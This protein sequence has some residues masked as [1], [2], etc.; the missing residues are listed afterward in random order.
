MYSFNSRVRYSEIDQRGRLSVPAVINYLQDCSTLQ[1]EDLGKG[2]SYMKGQH[3]AWWLSSWQIVIDRRPVLGEPITVSTWPYDF[4]G[5]YGYRNFTIQDKTGAYLVRANSVWFLFDTREGRPV[6]VGEDDVRGYVSG[7]ERLDMDYAARKIPFKPGEDAGEPFPVGA[8]HID[9]NHHVN[10]AAYVEMA[11]GEIPEDFEVGE[12]RADYKKAAV[13]G[14]IIVPYV[15]RG[16]KGYTVC[17]CGTDREPYALV[18]LLAA[19]A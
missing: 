4:R 7:E 2:V 17:L 19:K 16:E 1:S 15:E 6:R 11:M 3:R 12:V 13:K 9:T 5:I 10:N 18:Q 8:H 14:D